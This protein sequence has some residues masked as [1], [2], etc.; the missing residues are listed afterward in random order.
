ML[1]LPE[2][3]IM[4]HIISMRVDQ[5]VNVDFQWGDMLHYL[6]CICNISMGMNSVISVWEVGT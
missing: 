2:K 1:V 4:H 6:H 5:M 3:M